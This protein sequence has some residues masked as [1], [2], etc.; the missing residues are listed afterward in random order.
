MLNE[1][2]DR[3]QKNGPT[4]ILITVRAEKHHQSFALVSRLLT[5]AFRHLS[6][7]PIASALCPCITEQH[8]WRKALVGTLGAIISGVPSELCVIN[9]CPK[10][11]DWSETTLHSFSRRHSMLIYEQWNTR[12][13][14]HTHTHTHTIC[15]EK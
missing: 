13:H 15:V 6:P 8:I 9:D 10:L 3:L 11:W 2:C 4:A 1:C 7:A 14:T 12:L 5:S